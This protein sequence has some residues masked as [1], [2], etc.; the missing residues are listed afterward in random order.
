M[1]RNKDE[2]TD[3]IQEIAEICCDKC[4]NS[5]ASYNVG[6]SED[7]FF[8]RGWRAT[9]NKCYCPDCAKKYLKSV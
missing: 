6:N 5:D 7:T 1:G 3:Y 9:P 8:N 2:L 4:N